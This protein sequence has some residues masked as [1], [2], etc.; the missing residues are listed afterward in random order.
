MNGVDTDVGTNIND[1]AVAS[2]KPG[3]LIDRMPFK[4]PGY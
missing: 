4:L 3:A 2:D 1:Y